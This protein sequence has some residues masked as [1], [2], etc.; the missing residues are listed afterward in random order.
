MEL[1]WIILGIRKVSISFSFSS[2]AQSCLT[3]CNPMDCIMPGFTVHHQ[4]L[5][6]AQT[7]AH[8][9]SDAIQPS[10][11]LSPPPTF[12]LSQHQGLS[13]WVSP[14]HQVGKVSERQFQYQSF[15]WTF[16]TDC[17]YWLVG[18]PCSPRDCQE[19]FLPQFKSINSLALSFLNGLTL[20]SIHKVKSEVAQ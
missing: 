5:E 11:P 8:R 10:H 1:G 3:L 14:S 16:R 20:T 15:Q 9:V 7:H 12:S 2:V 6:L 13:Q 19:F 4:L 17:I 18:S